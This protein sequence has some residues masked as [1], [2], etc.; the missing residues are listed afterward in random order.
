M[1]GA[2]ILHS[3]CV[4]I[5]AYII[6]FSVNFV[7]VIHIDFILGNITR[8]NHNP[9]SGGNHNPCENGE[10]VQITVKMLSKFIKKSH[11]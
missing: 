10:P 9:C 7:N 3:A 1:R 11:I 4:G 8:G 5:I 6:I 2:S